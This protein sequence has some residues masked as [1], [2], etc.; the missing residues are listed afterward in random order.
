MLNK[1]RG[2]KGGKL[3]P[4]NVDQ[5]E[6][7]MGIKYEMEHTKL[8]SIAQEIALDHLSENPKYYS[9]LNQSGLDEIKR[10]QQLAGIN[11]LSVNLP[12]ASL[13]QLKRWKAEIQAS[14]D[15]MTKIKLA[16]KCAEGVMWIWRKEHPTDNRPQA[17]INAIKAY[18]KD[19]SNEN[20]QNCEKAADAAW[21][22][23]AD[24]A[25]AAATA[26]AA[27]TA[28]NAA[29]AVTN[30]YA[31]TYATYTAIKALTKYQKESQLNEL[32][33]YQNMNEIKRM[34]QL[35]G[36]N[37]LGINSPG[38]TLAQLKRWEAEILASDDEMTRIKLALKCAEGIIL[39]WHEKYPTD[40]RPQAAINALKNYIKDPSEE[41]AQNCENAADAAWDAANAAWDARAVAASNAAYAAWAATDNAAYAAWAATDNPAYANTAYA[42]IA[43]EA[44]AAVYA[45]QALT[46]HQKER[47]LND[48]F[49]L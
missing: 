4:K 26:N 21:N 35:A 41:N 32:K 11:E 47:Q 33:N 23:A 45:I 44:A 15:K 20:A 19:P 46:T 9:D 30:A 2:G 1:L 22:A 39:I 31:A 14:D 48:E 5:N 17:A 36:I 34:Q 8:A 43:E 10:M 12:R 29:Y 16:L 42:N 18:I 49:N 3:N 38:A 13:E 25:Y 27:N 7:K 40:N 28:A 37:E 6:L 24:D